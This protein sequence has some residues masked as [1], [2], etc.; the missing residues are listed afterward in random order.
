MGKTKK[1]NDL[2]SAAFVPGVVPA[3][4][5]LTAE[6][7]RYLLRLAHSKDPSGVYYSAS[8]T[9]EAIGLIKQVPAPTTNDKD[10]GNRTKDAWRKITQGSRGRDLSLIRNGVDE[11]LK[12][13]R[14]VDSACRMKYY[15][16]TP[17]GAEVIRSVRILRGPVQP[18]GEGGMR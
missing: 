18:Q 12:V 4:I 9:L 14:D 8:S 10:I 11:L 6:E 2:T 1:V 7:T 5:R 15:T 3:Q 16:L 13:Q 17:E